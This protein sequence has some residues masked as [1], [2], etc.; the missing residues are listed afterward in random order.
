MAG[1]FL[2]AGLAAAG[3]LSALWIW[4]AFVVAKRADDIFRRQGQFIDEDNNS[5]I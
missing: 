3:I 1:L 4:A 5:N 2:G